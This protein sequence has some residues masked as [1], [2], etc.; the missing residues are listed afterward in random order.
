MSYPAR[1]TTFRPELAHELQVGV[2]RLARR[3]RAERADHGLTLTQL[4]V[5]AT[6]SRHGPMTPGELA[7]HERVRPP[8]MTRTVASLVGAGMCSRAPDPDDGRQVIVDLTPEGRDL[9]RADRARRRAWLGS[10]LAELTPQ[11][12]ATLTDAAPLLDRL[13]GS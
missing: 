7:A 11:E 4:S 1:V 8:S 13:A 2:M 9:L 12:R 10:R 5:L 3:M 6:L